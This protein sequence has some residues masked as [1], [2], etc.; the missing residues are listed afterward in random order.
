MANNPVAANLVMLVL[1]VGG[2]I[3]LFM[4]V[5]QEVFPE[6]EIDLVRISIPYPG[7]SP[8]EVEKGIILAVEEAVQGLDG[9][10]EIRS[11]ATESMASVNVELRYDADKR[12]A[13]SD[14]K[15]EI[16]R[17]SSFPLDAEEPIVS[18][19][20]QRREVLAL[21]IYGDQDE[22]VLRE[23]AES[24][25]DDLLKEEKI[26]QVE[27]GGIR[28]LE[29]SIEVP[30]SRL[31]AYNLTIDAI[32][33]EIARS[34]IE[35]PGGGVKTAS[36]E[37]LLRTT[38]RRD[39]GKEF[40]DLTILSTKDGSQVKLKD[41]ARIQDGFEEQDV[42]SF[43][44]GKPSVEVGVYRIGDETPLEVAAA[45]KKYKE[46]L[47]K[48]LPP[49]I[50]TAIWRDRSEIFHQRIDLLKRNA[51]IGLF[52]VLGILGIFLEVR[53]A[54]WV[55]MG[56]P[57]SFLGSFLFLPAVDVS[58]NMISLFAF[59]ITLGMVVDDAIVVGESIYVHRQHG[60]KFIE[61]A[62]SGANEVSTP[63]IFSIMTT[64]TAF[65][66][67]F[68]V[69][70][71]MGKVFRILPSVVVIVLLLSL[72][73]SLYILPA[74]LG[75]LD[76]AK[77]TGIR[78][79]LHRLQQRFGKLVERMAEGIYGPM[80][81]W[82]VN[83]HWITWALG[84]F[85]LIVAIGFVSG[86]RINITFFPKIESDW[87]V[88]DA[89]LPYGVSLEETQKVQKQLEKA[90]WQVVDEESPG[91]RDKLCNGVFTQIRGSHL[92][93]VIAFL[94]PTD[95]RDIN[96]TDFAQQWRKKIGSVAGMES[97]IFDSTAGGPH[98]GSPIDIQL[99]HRDMDILER[100]A[101]ELAELLKAYEGV[102]DINDGFATGKSQLN[103]T[104][105]PEAQSLGLTAMELGR[106]MR[107]TFWGAE[108]IRQ[109]RG[110]NMI[111]V[112]VRLPR[113]ERT[114]EYDIEELLIRTP[115][116]GEMP[117]S[118]AAEITRGKSYTAISRTDGRR[119]VHVTAD[120]V[121]SVT[122]ARKVIASLMKKEI[123][124]LMTHY[125]GL[126]YSLEGAERQG[127]ESMKSL[128]EG[129]VIALLVMY[130]LIAIPF[131]RY[132]QPLAV[133][134]AIPFG[135]VG[136]IIG[137]VIMGY[138]LSLVSMMGLLALS[139]VVVNDSLIL[140]H[141]ANRMRD[142]GTPLK[143]AVC[144]AGVRRFR[145]ILLT[146]LTTFLG[147]TPMIFEMSLQARFLIPMAISLG[148]GVLFATFIILLMVP[149]FYLII[150][151]IKD[152][153]LEIVGDFG[154]IFG[155]FLKF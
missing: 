132:I 139:G 14:I 101:S 140:V 9:V 36:G 147:L 53:L 138:S 130:V 119:T 59:I 154:R 1:L 153:F 65:S 26:T 33:K 15:N 39:L 25:R 81:R 72:F 149:S 19:P 137:H 150:E 20:M 120:V 55:T 105:R 29:I 93:R 58:I 8:D 85:L 82:S 128:G 99:S 49:G 56:I 136:A 134:S 69:E 30:M 144:D 127:R 129:F 126:S 80:V 123:S 143:Q 77:E 6:F 116:G 31:R 103:F 27:L 48:V 42:A 37:V 145:P 135:I 66:P 86:G 97:L 43:F 131:K 102:I 16:D 63:V 23:L 110:R 34:A 122:S 113:E 121:A 142:E 50:K 22:K 94:V 47:D 106:Q 111:R 11:T 118:Q 7:A 2:A 64:I 107:N 28:P 95:Q 62:I 60:K 67:L 112:V 32:A 124:D 88:A 10:K 12:K 151:D 4:Q 61:A 87:V 52:L 91:Y 51:F 114:S 83:N 74:H 96:A 73:E 152:I 75:H 76:K 148:F 3:I 141:T 84:V 5:K 117:L 146:S 40:E 35:L 44:N 18:I 109:Q 17:I 125:P 98:G 24:V 70:G 100:A 54:F 68:F 78:G 155:K 45:V 21:V 89:T 71:T 79:R 57:I 133:L 46:R 108:A 92:I 115:G 13:I 90:L 38:E 41:I 104:I